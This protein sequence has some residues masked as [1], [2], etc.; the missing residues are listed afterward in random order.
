M[1]KTAETETVIVFYASGSRERFG[2]MRMV[3]IS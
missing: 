3:A 2:S 1:V